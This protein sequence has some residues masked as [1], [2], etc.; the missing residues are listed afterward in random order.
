MAGMNKLTKQE[1]VRPQGRTYTFHKRADR[2]AA[3]LRN[4]PCDFAAGGS[5]GEERFDQQVN[6]DA[7]VAFFHLG[8]HIRTRQSVCGARPRYCDHE[9]MVGGTG[10]HADGV[11]WPVRRVGS[12]PT[13]SPNRWAFDCPTRNGSRHLAC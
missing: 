7:R 2:G 12:Q 3:D 5:Q 9:N 13:R 4:R 11:A 6:R 1:R 10:R 8:D